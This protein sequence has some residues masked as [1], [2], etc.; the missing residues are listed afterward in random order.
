MKPKEGRER[1]DGMREE[2]A[3]F[4]RIAK[5]IKCKRLEVRSGEHVC[6]EGSAFIPK[7]LSSFKR[8]RRTMTT[9]AHS[10]KKDANLANAIR[11]YEESRAYFSLRSCSSVIF[12]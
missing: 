9:H 1:T 11:R 8:E 3:A 2:D 4:I 5:S 10:L 12:A 7:C 6:E